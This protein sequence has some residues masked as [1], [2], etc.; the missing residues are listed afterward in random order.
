MEEGFSSDGIPVDGTI[1]QQY[2][3]SYVVS[4]R[5]YLGQINELVSCTGPSCC[6]FLSAFFLIMLA[7]FDMILKS[8]CV[9]LLFY[10]LYYVILLLL[11]FME[12]CLILLGRGE[13]WGEMKI[14]C[15]PRDVF[16]FVSF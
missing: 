14:V 11:L 8:V 4:L 6:C 7:L 10:I 5:L 3:N 1:V 16:Q 9:L 15:P 13:F 2:S 12:G